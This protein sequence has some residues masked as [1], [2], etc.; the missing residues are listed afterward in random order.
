MKASAKFLLVLFLYISLPCLGGVSYALERI[1]GAVHLDT[2]VSDGVLSPEEMVERVKEAG[3]KVAVIT[4][5]DNQRVEYGIFP[6]RGIARE[7]EERQSVRTYG[8]RRYL[9]LIRD[10]GKRH[11]DMTVIAGLEAVPFY[12]WKGSYFNDDLKLM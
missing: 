3:L 10:I 11:P 5:K 12:Y 8:A 2:A 7:I 4:D 1:P 6:L 9:D